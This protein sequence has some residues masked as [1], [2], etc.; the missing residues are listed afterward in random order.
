MSQTKAEC[1]RLVPSH[2]IRCNGCKRWLGR[3]PQWMNAELGNGHSCEHCGCTSVIVSTGR[4]FGPRYR[5]WQSLVDEFAE[6]ER[7][8]ML[9]DPWFKGCVFT[10]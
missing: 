7:L 5:Y 10:Q 9:D 6:Y 3:L 8:K 1:L 4:P 2:A